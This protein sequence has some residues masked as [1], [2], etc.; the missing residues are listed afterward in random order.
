MKI[1][2]LILVTVAVGLAF[3]PFSGSTENELMKKR[4]KHEKSDLK[5]TKTES[6]KV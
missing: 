1:R 3:T 6:E 5:Q 4:V 2:I